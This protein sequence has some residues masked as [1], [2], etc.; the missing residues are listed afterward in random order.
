MA[1]ER[2]KGLEHSTS[3]YV[4][5]LTAFRA[6]YR[7]AEHGEAGDSETEVWRSRQRFSTAKDGGYD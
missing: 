3:F 7:G 5:A 6:K 2:P 1:V 4:P